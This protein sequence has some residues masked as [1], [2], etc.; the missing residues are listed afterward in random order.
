M[1]SIN[2]EYKGSHYTMTIDFVFNGVTFSCTK[3]QLSVLPVNKTLV[4]HNFVLKRNFICF[5]AA[6]AFSDFALIATKTFPF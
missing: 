4:A 6:H 2:V 3:L 1:I 5:G